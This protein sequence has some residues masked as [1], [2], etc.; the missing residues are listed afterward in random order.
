M[1]ITQEKSRSYYEIMGRKS[2][3]SKL[4]TESHNS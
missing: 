2:S 4:A 1:Q 3:S